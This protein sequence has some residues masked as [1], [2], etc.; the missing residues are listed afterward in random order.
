ML[1]AA[2]TGTQALALHGVDLET[3]PTASAVNNRQPANLAFGT[4][5]G[6]SAHYAANIEL[7]PANVNL[8]SFGLTQTVN[9]GLDATLADPD[10]NPALDVNQTAANPATAKISAAAKRGEL[11]KND[12]SDAVEARREEL[13]QQFD[14]SGKP[15]GS[16]PADAPPATIETVLGNHATSEKHI[17]RA[18]QSMKLADPLD[19]VKFPLDVIQRLDALVQTD[20]IDSHVRG[21]ATEAIRVSALRYL[22]QNGLNRLVAKTAAIANDSSATK[23]NRIAA[24][25]KFEEVLGKWDEVFRN[26][27]DSPRKTIFYDKLTQIDS[28]MALTAPGVHSVPHITVSLLD[29]SDSS[30]G[31]IVALLVSGFE[32]P[33]VAL[34]LNKP[35]IARSPS[36]ALSDAREALIAKTDF[37]NYWRLAYEAQREQGRTQF[38]SALTATNRAID[39][40]L[41]Y[42]TL[43]LPPEQRAERFDVEELKRECILL[44]DLLKQTLFAEAKLDMPGLTRASAA[45]VANML[46]KALVPLA[47]NSKDPFFASALPVLVERKNDLLR[48]TAAAANA[49]ETYWATQSIRAQTTIL[50]KIASARLHL[51]MPQFRQAKSKGTDFLNIGR[52]D[53]PAAVIGGEISRTIGNSQ[54]TADDELL[55]VTGKSLFGSVSMT[56][57][58]RDAQN[59]G[60]I[61]VEIEDGNRELEIKLDQLGFTETIAENNGKIKIYALADSARPDS[62]GYGIETRARLAA[63][64]LF[65]RAISETDISISGFPA[66]IR[67]LEAQIKRKQPMTPNLNYLR[68][69]GPEVGKI[70]N[71]GTFLKIRYCISLLPKRLIK[72]ITVAGASGRE[73]REIFERPILRELVAFYGNTAVAAVAIPN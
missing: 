3:R 16:A 55:S 57:I 68:H 41:R 61:R 9:P 12:G 50:K 43:T 36:S 34:T 67:E 62:G 13:A 59:G 10:S 72:T 5:V 65:G 39:Y 2:L 20:A 37:K 73:K 42:R 58:L 71:S 8:P 27:G 28:L 53:S 25:R 31:P 45:A 49:P 29:K 63:N 38:R 14:R 47:E 7:D 11:K 70:T 33:R 22:T 21:M 64:V 66:A 6:I 30:R 51:L 52:S 24:V 4:Y 17:R 56:A 35:A 19:A 23:E 48:E 26:P 40:I 1:A 44:S 69:F 54:V 46:E 60:S 15:S 32:I 18:L